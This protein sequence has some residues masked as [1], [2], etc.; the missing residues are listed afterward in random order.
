LVVVDARSPA[1]SKANEGE[2]M[3]GFKQAGT[4][5]VD[6][7]GHAG[8]F[9]AV[10]LVLAALVLLLLLGWRSEVERTRRDGSDVAPSTVESS[11]SRAEPLVVSPL[12]TL[13][14]APRDTTSARR[15]E[16]RQ[17]PRVI[18][19]AVTPSEATYPLGESSVLFV[20]MAGA[21]ELSGG[22]VTL[23]Y[24][25]AILKVT[26][27]R[28]CRTPA[29]F[30]VTPHIENLKGWASVTLV[31]TGAT[32][33]REAEGGLFTVKFEAIAEGR[34]EVVLTE[35]ALTDA[36]GSSVPVELSDGEV[37]VAG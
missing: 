4:G 7:N 25:P 22:V 17:L 14:V 24:D 37:E 21:R 27:V 13:H 19:L 16:R 28:P 35:A 3:A 23:V 31:P 10:P 2:W 20:T 11:R 36:R 6:G 30:T 29:P 33:Q 9:I 34:S 18:K 32:P 8:F 15:R 1:R 12:I 5:E 26:S